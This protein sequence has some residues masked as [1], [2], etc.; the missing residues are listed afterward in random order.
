MRF[1][2]PNF[3]K[4]G[5]GVSKDTPEKTGF[6]LFVDTLIGEFWNL[7]KLNFLF[8]LFSIPIIT[9][10]ASFAAL[11]N[12]SMKIARQQHIFVFYD[13]KESFKKNWKQSSLLGI[14]FL[15]LFSLITISLIFYSNASSN[16]NLL[17]VPL[18]ICIFI[19]LLLAFSFIYS[20]PLLTTVKLSLKDIFKNSFLLSIISLKNTLIAIALAIII[21]SISIFLL[22]FTIFIIFTLS[23]SLIAFANAFFSW[24]GIQQYVIKN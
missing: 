21:F 19:N 2:K 17:Y 8:L 6:A 13:F 20:F 16:N 18:F 11:T 15:L 14:I 24:P 5:K 12:V 9:I 7:I 10:P 1:L 23:F 22:P 4:E 3:E